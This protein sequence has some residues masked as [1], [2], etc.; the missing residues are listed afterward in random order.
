MNLTLF[1]KNLTIE[2][3]LTFLK[4]K[5]S[6]H[7]NRNKNSI[8]H[9]HEHDHDTYDPN[10]VFTYNLGMIQKKNETDNEGTTSTSHT[11]YYRCANCDIRSIGYIHLNYDTFLCANHK[12]DNPDII[13]IYEL[14]FCSVDEIIQHHTPARTNPVT[15][16]VTNPVTKPVTE[17]VTELVTSDSK[18]NE[19]QRNRPVYE[20]VDDSEEIVVPQT[21]S[22]NRTDEY[23]IK[24]GRKPKSIMKDAGKYLKKLH[25]KT[26]PRCYGVIRTTANRKDGESLRCKRGSSHEN[27]LTKRTYCQFHC[28]Q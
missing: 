27:T 11:H 28:F 17:P 3:K 23:P 24:M 15:D 4:E 1:Y 14:D 20:F 7:G 21:E 10:H 5:Y 6:L 12:I 25:G 19:Q 13:T 18:N 8:G 16:P 26:R 2:G 9:E 22:Q